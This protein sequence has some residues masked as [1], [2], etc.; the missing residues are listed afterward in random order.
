MFSHSKF[1]RR[2]AFTLV[3]LLVVIAIIGILIGMLLPAVQQVR[4]AARRTQCMNNIRQ[5]A[6]ACMNY[7]SAYMSFPPGLNCPLGGDKSGAFFDTSTYMDGRSFPREPRFDKFGSWLVWIMPFI[8]ANNAYELLNHNFREQELDN[9]RGPEAVGAQIIP[10]F[11][12][13]S[14]YDQNVIIYRDDFYFAPNSYFGVAGRQ[15]WFIAGGVSGDGILT[16][17]SSVTFGQI[18]D[19]SSNTLLIGERYSFDPEWPDFTNRRGWAWSSALS[20]QD[21]LSGVLEP[22]NYQLP[23]GVG[24]NPSFSL[25]DRKLNSFSSGHQGGANFAAADGSTHFLTNTGSA[26]LEVLEFLAVINDGNV[27]GI[28][29]AR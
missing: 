20:L 19:G 15:S 22:I 4:E 24:P 5:C 23:P 16:A 6:L 11:V 29:D 3:E 2:A 9:V 13:P 25:T 26:D 28:Q 21:C 12:C 7:E 10:A 8:E 27:V 17:N 14:D 1:S 18:S